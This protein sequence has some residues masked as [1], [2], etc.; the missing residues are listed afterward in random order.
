M[1]SLIP[2]TTI[3]LLSSLPCNATIYQGTI[4]A[5]SFERIIIGNGEFGT[6]G[7]SITTDRPVDVTVDS[8]AEL[9]Y[10][11]CDNFIT[12]SNCTFNSVFSPFDLVTN[13]TDFYYQTKRTIPRSDVRFGGNRIWSV[14][15]FWTSFMF[16]NL[17]EPVNYT[18]TQTITSQVPE[19]NTW[20]MSMLGFALIGSAA[21]IARRNSS[22]TKP[23]TSFRY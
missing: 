12:F 22:L 10:I 19:P 21:R 1:K 11:K 16:I 20:L 17:T 2:L 18:I 9:N 14:R 5:G 4:K 7:F 23:V 6:V 13:T 3:S 15:E 8:F